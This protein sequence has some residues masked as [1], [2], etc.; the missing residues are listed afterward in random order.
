MRIIFLLLLILLTSKVFAGN[1]L[2][3]MQF[4]GGGNKSPYIFTETPRILFDN[5][6]SDAVIERVMTQLNDDLVDIQVEYSKSEVDYD[7]AADVL[8]F[9][10]TA[11]QI[12]VHNGRGWFPTGFAANLYVVDG[13][14][15]CLARLEKSVWEIID[16]ESQATILRHELMHCLRWGHSFM[17]SNL[18][19][20][21]NQEV[22][23]KLY[24][25]SNKRR[26][27]NVSINKLPEQ[28]VDFIGRK[29]FKP[30]SVYTQDDSVRLYPGVY[31]VL[32]DGK[33]FKKRFKCENLEETLNIIN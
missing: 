19:A 4:S 7:R 10:R 24:D 5:D 28:R 12:F 17:T 8:P 18:D 27:C 20:F 26:T 22:L 15:T 25:K 13:A 32:V 14:A 29:K 9:Y 3:L 2:P 11:N 1:T 16:F 31:R 21:D 33:T 23:L 6:I 30:Y